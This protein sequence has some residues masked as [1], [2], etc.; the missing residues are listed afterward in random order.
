MGMF[1]LL[2]LLYPQSFS[3]LLLEPPPQSHTCVSD[4]SVEC[5]RIPDCVRNACLYLRGPLT[6]DNA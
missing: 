3:S 4:C 6:L 5:E 1:P 2:C